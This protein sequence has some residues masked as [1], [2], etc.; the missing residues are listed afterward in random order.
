VARN[1][2][3]IWATGVGI[4]LV[5][6]YILDRINFG[7]APRAV[8]VA[9]TSGESW[10]FDGLRN[11]FFLAVILVAVF[12]NQPAGLR[13]GLM[14][15]AAVGSYFAT[16]KSVHEANHF[17]FHPVREVAILFAGIFATMMPA[18]DWLGVNA[19]H[20]LG[21][22]PVPAMYYFG[23]GGLSAVLDNA[24]TYL[25]FVSALSGVTETPD[26]TQL[27]AQH[28]SSMLA[29]SFGAVF[30]GAATYIGNGP[31]FMVKAIA[32]HQDGHAPTFPGFILRYTLPFLLPMLM[33]VWW[34]FF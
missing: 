25:A 29:I 17:D 12:V 7:R 28:A 16:P 8:R 3:M 4:L 33:V 34:L 26:M 31:N 32:D 18:L 24:P 13:E 2:W 10:R 14:L 1:G 30:F 20:L 9:E 21:A 15:A 27:L 22:H 23:V 11:L 5:L 19:S 6:F